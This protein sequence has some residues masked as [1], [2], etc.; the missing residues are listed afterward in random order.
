MISVVIPVYNR[1]NVVKDAINSVLNQTIRDIEVIVIDDGSKDN[2]AAIIKSIP[3]PRIHYFC[4]D[5]AG[6][7]VARNNGISK[8]KGEYIAFH[9]SDDIWHKDKLEKQMR[10][11]DAID[12]DMV[13]CKMNVINNGK[14]RYKIPKLSEGPIYPIVNLFCIGTQTIVAKRYVFEE[15][16]FDPEMPRFQ[17]F[18][19]LYRIA[20]KYKIY[21]VGEALV[22]YS[23]NEDSITANPQKRYSACELLQRKHPEIVMKYPAMA[24]ELACGLQVDAMNLMKKGNTDYSRY[25]K[26]SYEFDSSIRSKVRVKLIQL[27]IYD[28]LCRA[29]AR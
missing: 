4:Q 8:A 15:F 23:V 29:F 26:K 12:T 18:E 19:L 11:F 16:Q 6:A 3:D 20:Q 9:D 17:D 10:I 14:V 21:C 22:D 24:A 1:E 27:G 2:S 25:I 5:N 7:C 13:V 28:L